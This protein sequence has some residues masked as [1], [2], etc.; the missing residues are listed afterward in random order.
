MR[1]ISTLGL[2]CS[3]SI[4]AM[5]TSA[6]CKMKGLEAHWAF[7]DGT[8]TLAKNSAGP[9]DGE[10]KGDLKWTDGKSGKALVFDGKGYVSAGHA[11]YFHSPAYTLAAWTRLKDTGTYHYIAW[12]A[13][14]VYP[15]EGFLR[16]MDVWVHLGGT[17]HGIWDYEKDAGEDN[18]GHLIGKQ[19]ITDD[20][21]HLV[22]WVYD[23]EAMKLYVDGK[24]DAEAKTA[25]PL[26]KNDFPLWIGAR[27]ANVAAVGIIDEVRF[28]SRAL[29][30]DEIASLFAK[31]E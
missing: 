4:A 18:R 28:F 16:R 1:T 30:A 13:G 5:L 29:G 31:G 8:G 19:K 3:L 9:N 6:G 25:G 20:Q 7:N 2:A 10:I 15:E 17:V 23:G 24:L 14:P 22:V 21:W 26:A 11:A 27:P 12:K